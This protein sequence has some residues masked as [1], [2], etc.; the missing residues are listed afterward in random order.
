V[1]TRVLLVEDS[2]EDAD[3][4]R[5]ALS[6]SQPAEYDVDRA[7]TCHEAVTHLTDHPVDVILLDLG[8]PDGRGL[9][10]LV[11]VREKAHQAA[12]VVLTG[13][14][15]T[16]L[17]EACLNAGAQGYLNK[18]AMDSRTLS[19]AIRD[20]VHRLA[21]ENQRTA[22]TLLTGYHSLS[23]RAGTD[24][25]ASPGS[26]HTSFITRDPQRLEMLV[27][28]YTDL[29]N[30]YVKAIRL[31][32]P[33]PRAA[34]EQ[35][36]TV[37]GNGGGGPQ[38]LIDVHLAALERTAAREPEARGRVLTVDGRLMALEMMG[39]LVDYYRKGNHDGGSRP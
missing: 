17:E 37:I 2:Q 26:E 25:A 14:D 12:I 36:V 20:S 8:L 19:R 38:D 28:A 29:L 9:E 27:D 18:D 5:S 39:F 32:G 30:R 6:L 7:Q 23:S 33:R 35:V 10:V 1:P 15:D 3:F 4:V 24:A 21:G 16:R 34:M 11:A 13:S 31:R 22:T